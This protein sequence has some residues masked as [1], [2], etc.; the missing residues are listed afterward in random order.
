MVEERIDEL[1]AQGY[2]HTHGGQKKKEEFIKAQNG[3][4]RNRS[5]DITMTA[6]DGSTYR[7]NV[8]RASKSGKPVARERWALDD[9]ERAKG[10]RPEFIPYNKV[11]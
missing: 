8:G 6:P 7:A 4:R 11:K 1:K 3:A 5:P 9:I 2:K 10:T